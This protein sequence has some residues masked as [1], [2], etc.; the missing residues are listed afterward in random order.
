VRELRVSIDGYADSDFEERAELA[1]GLRSDMLSLDDVE[2]SHPT[3]ELPPGAKG[4]AYDWAQLVVE[5]AGGLG[6]LIAAV[7]GWASE[8]SGASVTVEMDGDRLVIQEPTSDERRAVVAA[9]L[10]RHGGA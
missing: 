10:K 3:G 6:P 2:V 8:R 9:W 4:S 5:F 7:H 1:A